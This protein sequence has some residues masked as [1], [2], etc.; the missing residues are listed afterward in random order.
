MRN[1]KARP[2]GALSTFRRLALAAWDD[3]RDPSI[4]GTLEVDATAALAHLE[5]LHARTGEHATLTHLVGRALAV[6]L[7]ERPELHMLVR[8]GRLHAREQ[9]DIFF[10]VALTEAQAGACDL[11]GLVIRAADRKSIAAIAR[12][13][14]E[15]LTQIRRDCDPQ[16]GALRRR[17]AALPPALLRPVQAALDV[18][19]YRLN[20]RVPGLPRDAFG[21]AAVSNVGMFGVRWAHA[22]LFP[23]AHWPILLLVGAVKP[24]PWA[25]EADGVARVEVRPVLPLHATLDHR[26]LDGLQ[27]ARLSTR[28][29]EL[30]TRPELLDPGEP[31]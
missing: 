6:V 26:V 17:L 13:F 5:A 29:E 25:V 27:A 7:A 8:R 31:G 19:E 12:E 30:L 10:Q 15:R 1:F 28:M 11:S 2:A 4:H 20:L 14:G 24:R 21:S 3:P 16:L 9:V 22:P 23:P 18:V